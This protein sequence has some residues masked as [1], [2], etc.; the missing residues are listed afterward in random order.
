[1]IDDDVNNVS[2]PPSQLKQKGIKEMK[3][4]FSKK[5]KLIFSIQCQLNWKHLQMSVWKHLL[6]INNINNVWS[7]CS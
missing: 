3:A 4:A 1:M 2:T 6:I 5:T 7:F